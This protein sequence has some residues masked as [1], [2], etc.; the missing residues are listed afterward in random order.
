MAKRKQAPHVISLGWTLEE[1]IV[2]GGEYTV[3]MTIEILIEA[4]HIELESVYIDKIEPRN[5]DEYRVAIAAENFI[6]NAA[7][8]NN[9]EWDMIRSAVADK[10][11]R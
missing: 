2:D 1:F 11:A 6:E 8:N 9:D 4:D 10:I 5:S 3:E 7:A